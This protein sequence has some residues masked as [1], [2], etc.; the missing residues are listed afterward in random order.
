MK[1]IILGILTFFVFSTVSAE[2]SPWNLSGQIQLR[3]E[4][5][6]R[7]FSNKTEA[8]HY[9]SMRTRLS[10]ANNFFE[11][12]SFF[13]QIQD[14]RIFGSTMN[15]LANSDNLDIHQAN[16][17]LKEPLGIPISV[18]AGRFEMNYGTQR[19]IGAVGWHYVGRTFD[20]AIFSYN[21]GIS[22]DAFALTHSEYQK[23]IPN[24]AASVYHDSLPEN[25]SYSIY[26]VWSKKE[27]GKF[28]ILDLFGYFEINRQKNIAGDPVFSM[29]TIGTNYNGSF[30]DFSTLLEAAYQ[31]GNKDAM[32]IG[33]YL[34]SLQGNYK[35]GSFS[36]GAGA[37]ILSGT[38]AEDKET[39][40]TFSPT[41]GTNHKFYG[42]MDYFINIPSNTNLLGLHDFYLTAKWFPKNSDFNSAADFHVF[43][44]DKED[45]NGETGLGNEIDLTIN[46]KMNKGTTVTWGGSLFM[47]GELMKSMFTTVKYKKEDIAYWTYLMIQVSL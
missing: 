45:M 9:T 22:I 13:V 18:K 7:D 37:D 2:D 27:L 11:N 6:G 38:D 8:I 36:F 16:I 19:F 35:I 1:I 34:I 21:D 44:T 12:V 25:N 26:G 17:I 15:T 5:D 28:H 14:S 42:Y 30:G 23:Y 20:G 33:A 29:G 31:L 39:F 47:P 46:Y 4:V 43:T 32:D 24:A 41:Y 10:V 40:S 3:S